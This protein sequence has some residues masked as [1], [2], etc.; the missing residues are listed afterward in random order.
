M[1]HS[2]DFDFSFS[3]LKTDVL[4]L[5]KSENRKFSQKEIADICASFQ[6]AVV[7][8]LVAKTLAAAQK[9]L[10][11]DTGEIKTI[12]LAGGVS[13]NQSLREKMAQTIAQ[14]FPKIQFLAPD[15]KFCT[16]NAAMI[17]QVG[18]EKLKRHLTTTWDKLEVDANAKL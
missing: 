12:A 4:R 13:A 10:S 6:A 15:L 16:D 8:T 1:L 3:G 11:T 17:A 2:G 14:K 7:D 9:Y 5:V 18:Q